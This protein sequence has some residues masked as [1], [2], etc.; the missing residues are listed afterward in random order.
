[1]TELKLRVLWQRPC[2]YRSVSDGRVKTKQQG[3]SC[4]MTAAQKPCA[5]ANKAGFPAASAS[6]LITFQLHR[7]IVLHT[8]P[9]LLSVT[10]FQKTHRKK[11]NDS[12][13]AWNKAHA[14]R[15]SFRVTARTL[16]CE[17]PRAWLNQGDAAFAC[18]SEECTTCVLFDGQLV[19]YAAF[20]GQPRLPVITST[21]FKMMRMANKTENVIWHLEVRF[22]KKIKAE[23]S[24]L[25]FPTS[26]EGTI[27]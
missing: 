8:Q 9:G 7:H 3:M 2:T 16:N 27:R 14:T 19:T 23:K 22:K 21:V 1:M 5:P 11:T 17:W 4:G 24:F 15:Q 12:L 25:S 18:P 20:L 6:S 13:T 26:L 10:G